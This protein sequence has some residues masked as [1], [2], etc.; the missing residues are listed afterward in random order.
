MTRAVLESGARGL[1]WVSRDPGLITNV[2]TEADPLLG[3]RRD[4]FTRHQRAR[5]KRGGMEGHVYRV[6]TLRDLR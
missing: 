3:A 2:A 1:S 5:P 6:S 4:D